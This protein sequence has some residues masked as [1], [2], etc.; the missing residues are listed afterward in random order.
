MFFH[1][2]LQQSTAAEILETF[3]FCL[4]SVLLLVCLAL[5]LATALRIAPEYQRLVV[6]RL[7]R[8]LGVYG[9][10]LFFLLPFIDRAVKVDLREQVRHIQDGAVLTAD[11]AQVTVD[12]LWNYRVIDPAQATLAVADLPGALQETATAT[13]RAVVGDMTLN[14]VLAERGQV[15][16]ETHARLRQAIASWGVE[17]TN[18]QVRDVWKR[19]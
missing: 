14:Q 13:L 4:P 17:V 18:L 12:V 3:S 15:A 11:D 10:G 16:A 9:P 8:F 6:F 2:W 1:I 5:V 7:G 19:F